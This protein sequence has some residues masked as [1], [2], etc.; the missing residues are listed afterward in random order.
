M[1]VTFA[2]LAAGCAVVDPLAETAPSIAYVQIPTGTFTMG[3]PPDEDGHLADEEPQHEVTISAFELGK[4]EVTNAEY[5]RFLQAN[6]NVQ[7]PAHWHPEIQP[8]DEPA[9]AMSWNEAAQFASWVGGRLPTEAEWEYAARAGTTESRYGDVDAVAWH[10]L[11]SDGMKHK[12]GGKQPNAFGL[13]DMLGNVNEWVADG[14]R[15]YDADPAFDPRDRTAESAD[16]HVLRGGSFDG[17]P[18]YARAAFRFFRAPHFRVT[19]FGFRVAR[20]LR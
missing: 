15:G 10:N 20:E 5:A 6:P 4:Y 2:L 8:D 19:D 9:A 12:V 18:I 1:I 16:A 7:L 13:Y 3:S 14:M 17:D 11:N